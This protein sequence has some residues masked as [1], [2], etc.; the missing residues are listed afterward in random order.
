MSIKMAKERVCN[1][2]IKWSMC[3]KGKQKQKYSKG[4]MSVKVHFPLF[5]RVQVGKHDY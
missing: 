1:V 3:S 5:A 2:R 4:N